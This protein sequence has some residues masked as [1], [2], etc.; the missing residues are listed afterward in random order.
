MNK[1][2]I[3]IVCGIIAAVA[4]GTNPLFSLNLYHMGL[5]VPS[6]LFYRFSVAAVVLGI[7]LKL[8]GRSLRITRSQGIALLTGGITF[9]L[10]SWTLYR[11]FLYMD[12]GIACAILFV[13]PMLVALIM[14]IFYH[15]KA[16]PV[17]LGCIVLAMVGIVLLYQ[18]DGKTT[19]STV[20]VIL[21][22][23]SSLCY[24]IYI[25]GVD[26]SRLHR[27][28]SGKLTF[29]VLL[30]GALLFLVMTGC[31]TEL[32]PIPPTPQGWI[33][34]LGIALVPTIIPIFFINIAIK[35][36]GPTLSAILGALEPVTAMLIGVCVFGEL[37]TLRIIVGTLLILIAVTVVVASR[38]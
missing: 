4:Y 10:S 6:V 28:E 29:W 20:G 7:I 21:V 24:A 11:S 15:E 19:L 31:A 16:S 35:Q 12:A 2:L 23:L 8:Q 38:K 34:V 3:G 14:I 22:I 17:T 26:H 32:H 36:V 27:I 5:D 25:V 37:I 30:S 33:N 9:A 18:G 1:R 13:Y